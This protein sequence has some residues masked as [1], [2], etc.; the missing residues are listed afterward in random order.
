MKVQQVLT[1]KLLLS[2]D[3][4]IRWNSHDHVSLLVQRIIP[5][6]EPEKKQYWIIEPQ[7]QTGNTAVIEKI[8]EIES[9]K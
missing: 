1:K 7:K 3:A 2:S 6:N 4:G 5:E 8:P 9:V